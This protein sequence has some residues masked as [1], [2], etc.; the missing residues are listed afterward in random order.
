MLLLFIAVSSASAQTD[1]I[2][3]VINRYTRLVYI[4]C[5]NN[6][7]IQVANSSGFASGDK[8][9]IIQ[10][11]GAEIDRADTSTTTFGNVTWYNNAG[12]YELATI[13]EINGRTF[14]LQHELA[15]TYTLSGVVQVVRVPSYVNVVI[16]DTL[17][18]QK[19][20]GTTGGVLAFIASGTVTMNADINAIGSGFR[21]GDDFGHA[22]LDTGFNTYR[23][24]GSSKN[25][26]SIYSCM[27]PSDSGAMKGEG[28]HIGRAVYLGG[29]GALSNAGGGGNAQKYGSGG[30]G[31]GGNYGS[32]GD[33]GGRMASL[34]ED[35]RD[36]S[37]LG[38]RALPYSNLLNRVHL[39]GSGG[40][41]GLDENKKKGPGGAGGGI[42]FIRANQIDG[43]GHRIDAQGADVFAP[44]APDLPFPPPYPGGGGGGG[45]VIL[46][47]VPIFSDTVIA[48]A[49]GGKGQEIHYACAGTGGGGGGGCIWLAGSSSSP[50][51]LITQI[52]GG[53][54]GSQMA[55]GCTTY[56]IL[57]GYSGATGGVLTGLQIPQG[58]VP[59]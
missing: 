34:G 42:I 38:G 8:I 59:R 54:S 21:G 56:P 24:L 28:I 4:E 18:P 53:T 31:G 13:D 58:T 30:G 40:W 25:I 44:I 27:V 12:N 37:G 41:G 55:S 19:W 22:M 3:G 35:G 9:L 51:N 57:I 7:A 16:A 20:N 49:R 23:N 43:N 2:S 48:N 50:T 17:R 47:D 1:T 10:M 11:Q 29:K 6:S 36:C 39:G 45:G 32:G 14:I 52:T 46:L 5:T 26:A 15:R 33:G